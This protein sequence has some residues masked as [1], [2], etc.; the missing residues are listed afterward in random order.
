M[1]AKQAKMLR[2]MK[3]TRKEAAVYNKF[4]DDLKA[5]LR[6]LYSANY[7]NSDISLMAF[8]KEV[9]GETYIEKL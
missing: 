1:N 4:S 6:G 5:K 7:Q 9:H 8:L 3:A 2:K